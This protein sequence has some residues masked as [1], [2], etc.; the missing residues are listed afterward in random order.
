MITNKPLPQK[1]KTQLAN[2]AVFPDKLTHAQL[3]CKLRELA[4]EIEFD[5]NI[6]RPKLFLKI[7]KF[8]SDLHDGEFD[9]PF[10]LAAALEEMATAAWSEVDESYQS[11]I[12][13][14]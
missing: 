7:E 1:F 12:K 6:P 14:P 2:L 10:D 13:I 9:Q 5:R 8:Y 11:A 4:A 3:A